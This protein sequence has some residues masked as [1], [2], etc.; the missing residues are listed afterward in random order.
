MEQKE[1]KMLTDE[2]IEQMLVNAANGEKLDS[3]TKE[4]WLNALRSDNYT[5]G[6][7]MLLVQ[8]LRKEDRSVVYEMCC[9]G[10]LEHVL[11]T[12]PDELGKEDMCYPK[13]L[14]APKSPEFIQSGMEGHV[15]HVLATLNDG[16]K[17][18]RKHSFQEIANLI[19]K[20]L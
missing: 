10:V 1:V 5:Q 4:L 2:Q 12:N 3:D 8:V 16:N 9:L 18:I 13:N 20:F 15:A 6:E 14:S 17:I 19:E 7:G 11:G